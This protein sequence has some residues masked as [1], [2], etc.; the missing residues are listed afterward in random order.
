MNMAVQQGRGQEYQSPAEHVTQSDRT[1][2]EFPVR[3][4]KFFQFGQIIKRR[5]KMFADSVTHDTLPFA[6]NS[7][8]LE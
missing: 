2:G 6:E 4:R 1:S 3:P 5:L 8:V 7:C